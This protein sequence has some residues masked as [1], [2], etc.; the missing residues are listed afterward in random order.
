M[1]GSLS[2]AARVWGMPLTLL[3][4]S[5]LKLI[6]NHSDLAK[7]RIGAL[8]ACPLAP[9]RGSKYPAALPLD[10]NLPQGHLIPIVE[11]TAV[12]SPFEPHPNHDPTSD[13]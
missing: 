1:P 6:Y 9:E 4:I 8:N 5:Y 11:P 7:I 2:L 12:F 3:E 13:L 10:P